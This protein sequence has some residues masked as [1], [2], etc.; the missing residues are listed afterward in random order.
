MNAPVLCSLAAL[1][2]ASACHAAPA[3]VAGD[4]LDAYANVARRIYAEERSGPPVR[5]SLRRIGRDAAAVRGERAELLRQLFLP[6]FHVVRLRVVRGG[7]VV[8]DVGGRFVV[9]GVSHDGLEISIQDVIGYVK[10]VHAQ[11]G[12]GVVVHGRPGHVVAS[13]PALAGVTLP[14]DGS[15]TVAGRSYLV[16]SFS[17]PGFAGERLRVWILGS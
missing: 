7:R 16:R 8:G 6:R 11:T 1:A 3:S 10:L 13:S 2:V 17:E 12:E 9:G 5:A 4:H 14:A 15:V